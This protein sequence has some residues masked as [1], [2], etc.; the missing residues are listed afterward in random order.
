M[1]NINLVILY[2][3]CKHIYKD[4]KREKYPV[5]HLVEPDGI[6]RDIYIYDIYVN[7]Q[8]GSWITK[9]Q[10]FTSLTY[11]SS[12]FLLMS[13]V[14]TCPVSPHCFTFVHSIPKSSHRWWAFLTEGLLCNFIWRISSPKSKDFLHQSVHTL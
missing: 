7:L 8:T 4:I 11:H 1:K 12:M 9:L 13:A 2:H 6:Y 5:L 3:T 14:E 10:I